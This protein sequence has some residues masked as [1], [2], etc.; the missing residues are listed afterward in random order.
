MTL[1]EIVHIYNRVGFGISY[2]AASALQNKSRATIVSQVFDASRKV[3]PLTVDVSELTAQVRNAQRND[4]KKLRS[5][6]KDSVKKVHELNIAWIY[7]LGTTQE[8]LREKMTLFWANHF[9]CHDKNIL[10]IQQ[11]NN[12]L[13]KHALGNFKDFV[14]AISKE[15]AM[16]KYLNTKQNKKEKPNE[17]FARELMELFTLGRDQYS[18]KDIKEAARAFTGWNHD[19]VGNFRLRRFQH[20]YGEKTFFGETGNFDGDDIIEIIL[21]QKQC[22]QFI[23]EKVYRYF[24]N[25]QLDPSRIREMTEVFYKDYD[26]ENLMRFVLLSDWFYDQK[27][28]G[29][30][31]KS[32]VEFL[33]G[34]HNVV[35]MQ[36][37]KE[38]ELVYLQKLLGQHLLFPPNVAGWKGGRNW[39]NPN[40]MML[41]LNL[42]S[43]L[44]AKGA[45]A[46]DEKGAFED[47][48]QRFNTKRNRQRKLKV[49]PDWEMFYSEQKNITTTQLQ[50]VL[51]VS[52]LNKGTATYLDKLADQDLK[53]YCI[54]LMSLPEYQLC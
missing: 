23:C 40:T 11:Y 30:K 44:L 26:I 39:I 51:L 27:N 46:L 42:P 35:P 10:H 45:I 1:Q 36:F 16:I 18:E 52:P 50:Q 6:I 24:V 2:T 7:R 47:D 14:V 29:T 12:T 19:F 28:I 49:L 38:R 5:L 9:V 41:R 43:I 54:Q 34:V 32:P 48:F 21:K 53:E 3:K 15:A 37:E 8:V 31:I 20:D 22:A 33:V 13:R 17:N 4:R 25:D